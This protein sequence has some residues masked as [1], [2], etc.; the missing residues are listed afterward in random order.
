[1]IP[2]GRQTIDD[3]D[4]AAVVGA[5][6]SDFLTTGP[7]VEAFENELAE[8]VGA[9]HVI[10]V[11][12]GTAALHMAAAAA[13]IAPGDHVIT[14]ANTFL[15]SANCAAYLGATPDFADIDLVTYNLSVESL[16]QTWRTTTKAVIAVDF[17]GQPCDYPKITQ[18]ARSRGATVIQDASHS[19]GGRA[20]G[21]PVGGLPGV[22]LTTFSFH[23]VKTMTTGEGGAVATDRD[24]FAEFCREFRSHGM[25]REPK[26]FRALEPDSWVYEMQNLGFNYR[27]TDLQCALG[28]SQLRKLDRFVERRAEIVSRYNQA[29]KDLE[30]VQ[31][32]RVPSPSEISWHL[33]VVQVDFP[34]IGKIRGE[35]MNQLREAGVGTQVHY[36]PVHL[37]PWYRDH[38]GYLPGKC[39]NAEAYYQRALSLPLYPAMSDL[40]ISQVIEAVRTVV[41]TV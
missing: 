8:Y 3:D 14:S 36:I 24:D 10:A 9:K 17:A 37:Q 13:G 34:A 19:L 41:E 2:Y 18:L 23:P 39:P 15:A 31:I 11:N 6:N 26:K 30:H 16:Q 40:G 32:P 7:E 22:D 5:L 28:R 35:V 20:F 38:F 12:S 21:Y 1:V 25:V 29:F 4:I 27:I 33:Y